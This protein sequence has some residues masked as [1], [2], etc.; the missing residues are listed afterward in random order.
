MTLFKNCCE[1]TKTKPTKLN[2]PRLE[3]FQ[4]NCNLINFVMEKN[5]LKIKRAKDQLKYV[6]NIK[7][8]TIPFVHT[9]KLN[10]SKIFENSWKLFCKN[11][12]LI[13]SY[14]H[15]KDNDHFCFSGFRKRFK[16][17]KLHRKLM[18]LLSSKVPKFI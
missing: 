14:G 5:H 16:V 17:S 11:S 3:L 18:N 8:I 10:N 7:K 2:H 15:F 12:K 13:I 4:S 6:L 9:N 1:S